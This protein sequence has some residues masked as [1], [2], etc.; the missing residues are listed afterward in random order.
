METRIAKRAIDA[1]RAGESLADSEIKGF[2]AR[3]LPSGTVT[4]GFR[5]RNRAGQQRWLPIGLHGR[6]TPD[7]ARD[8]AKKRAG[9][10]ADGRDPMAERDSQRAVAA[11]TVDSV[12]D[13]FLARYV[14]KQERPLKSADEIERAFNVYIRPRIG[15]RSIYDLGRRDIVE[16][17]DEIE[18]KNGPVMCDR[19]L[20]Y[21]RKAFNWQASRDEQFNSPIVRGMQRTKP[22]ERAR[23]RILDDQ[24][25]RD[26]WRA[27]DMTDLPAPFPPL[28]KSL[29]FTAQRRDEIA[30]M[31]WLEIEEDCWVVPAERS[32]NGQA[33]T[34]PLVGSVRELLGAR[35]RKGYVFTTTGGRRPFSGF[36]KAKAALDKTM[37]V[38]RKAEGRKPSEPWVLHDLRRTARSLM[39][40][41]GVSAD[42]AERV[43]GHVI[44]GVRGVYDRFGY[45]DEK[46]DALEKLA[47]LVDRILHPEEAVVTF[48]KNPRRRK[49]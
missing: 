24:E 35:Q 25:I 28:V 38:L 22:K 13:K 2:V 8:F 42:I 14:R 12:L 40:R 6:V 39:S 10:V 4:Y 32:K 43:L 36:S 18:D 48:P 26:L 30:S 16:L 44:P 11:N 7:E 15:Q 34:M 33:N 27:L 41:A 20:A 37:T 49:M 19:V 5:Y 47:A 21:L 46:R 45:L 17:L 1:L 23:R 3:R 31:A 9:E 29:L